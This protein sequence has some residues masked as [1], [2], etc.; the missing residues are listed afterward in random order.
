MTL[1]WRLLTAAG[2]NMHALLACRP[3]LSANAETAITRH[4]IFITVNWVQ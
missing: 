1:Q 2:P 3:C 4:S